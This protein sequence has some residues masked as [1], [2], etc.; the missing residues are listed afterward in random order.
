MSD[1]T[2]TLPPELLEQLAVRVADILEERQSQT[3]D[4]SVTRWLT[5]AEAAGVLGVDHKTVRSAIKDG[6]LPVARLGRAQRV[7][8]SDLALLA[9]KRSNGTV[10]GPRTPTT[11]QKT[12]AF[13]RRARSG[14]YD[15]SD[16]ASGPA[17]LVRP[18]PGT[19]GK[20]DAKR[21]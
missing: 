18:G 6:R 20:P 14:A 12:G 2:F 1:F 15:G 5:I 4:G 3:G 21:S 9:T 13:S 11:R 19:G 8:E 17:A 10:S 16:N 7:L